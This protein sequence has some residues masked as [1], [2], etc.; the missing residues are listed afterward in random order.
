MLKTERGHSHAKVSVIGELGGCKMASLA[1]FFG[2]NRSSTCGLLPTCRQSDNMIKQ[3]KGPQTREETMKGRSLTALTAFLLGSA[4]LTPAMAITP[5][6]S[7][8]ATNPA[9][10]L[11]GNAVIWQSGTQGPDN[12]G[13][14]TPSAVI[15]PATATVPA[16]CKVNFQYSALSGPAQGYATG[17]TQ[18]IGIVIGRDSAGPPSMAPGTAK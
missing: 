7:Q 4:C 11:A 16:Y 6:C 13:L 1:A 2:R 5:T 3:V 18:T 12:E 15:V 9:Y 10:G 8:I 14:M 17:Q